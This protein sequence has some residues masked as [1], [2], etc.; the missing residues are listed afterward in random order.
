M[1][2]TNLLKLMLHHIT[3]P[4]ECEVLRCQRLGIIQQEMGV[5][6]RRLTPYHTVIQVEQI[7]HL[8]VG[9]CGQGDDKRVVESGFEV[10]VGDVL[11]VYRG[12]GL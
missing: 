5:I 10:K 8:G 6:E 9:V 2:D 7:V 1:T 4:D 11:Y 3:H 12:Q